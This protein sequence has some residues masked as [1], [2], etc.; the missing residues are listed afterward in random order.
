M[1]DEPRLAEK[2]GEEVGE[3]LGDLAELGED[4]DLFLPRR[5]LLGELGQPAELAAAVGEDSS[6]FKKRS[7]GSSAASF[8][9]PSLMLA[10][11]ITTVAPA[12]FKMNDNSSG[13]RKLLIGT[14][15]PPLRRTPKKAGMYSGQFF[16]QSATRS[17][18]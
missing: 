7:C 9:T 2:P 17:P 16:I 5:E 11:T 12:S 3:R 18:G 10:S 4:Q 8:S 6:A 13:L 14:T 1:Q 15:T